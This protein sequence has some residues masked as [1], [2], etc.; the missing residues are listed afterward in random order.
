MYMRISAYGHVYIG[1]VQ[2]KLKPDLLLMLKL[3]II[4]TTTRPSRKGPIVGSW[5]ADFAREHTDF[6]VELLDLGEINLPMMDEAYHPRLKKYQHEHTKNWSK[7][8]DAADAFLIVCAEY[9]H[10]FPAP[11]KNALDYLYLEWKY[12]PV[13]F[14]SYGG[15]SAGTRAVE[16]LKQV[17]TTLGMVPLVEAVHISFFEQYITD[18]E[19]FAASD[20]TCKSAKAML[21]AL[22]RWAETLR[23]MRSEK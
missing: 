6:D 17:V 8:I 18:E 19:Q 16:M 9:N 23:P 5:T 1:Y 4:T 14:V 21:Q 11:I 15:V 10:G 13:G 3:K 12:K 7:T 20:I 2:Y 22:S